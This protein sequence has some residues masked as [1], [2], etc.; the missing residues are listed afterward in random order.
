M[1]LILKNQIISDVKFQ[2]HPK[3][4]KSFT[5]DNVYHFNVTYSGDGSRCTAVLLQTGQARGEPEMFSFEVK[6]T[7]FFTCDEIHT[8]EDKRQAHVA[9][10]NLLFPHMQAFVRLLTTQT[11]MPPLML[12]PDPPRPENIEL[13]AD[14]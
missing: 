8:D 9:A 12:V 1:E 6:M 4:D 5:L 14:S 11:G 7:G 10:Y 13:S 3:E 2:A